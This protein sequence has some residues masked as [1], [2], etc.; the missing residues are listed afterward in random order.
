[1]LTTFQLKKADGTTNV[2]YSL[3][4]SS[5]SSAQYIDPTSSLSAPRTLK[6][7][8]SLKSTGS[9]GSDRH[10]ILVQSVVLDANNAPHTMS[11]SLTWTIPRA[12]QATDVLSKDVVAALRGYLTLPGV[13]DALIDGIIP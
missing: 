10:T 8:H 4:G 11:A 2:A 12:A 3:Q 7:S 5:Q 6:V 9:K 1:M 13:E